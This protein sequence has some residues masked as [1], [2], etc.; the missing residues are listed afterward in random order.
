LRPSS[1]SSWSR[2][3]DW[4]GARLPHFEKIALAIAALVL[5]VYGGVRLQARAAQAQESRAFD[6]A[7]QTQAQERFYEEADQAWRLPGESEEAAPPRDGE[8]SPPESVLRAEALLAP[9]PA[10]DDRDV[11]EWSPRRRRA[12]E[13]TL[14]AG[15]SLPLGRLEIPSIDLSVMV[16]PGTDD[17]TLN[18]AVGHIEGTALPGA[19]EGNV[20]IAGHRDG[21]FR[22]LRHLRQGER[23]HL[24]TLE[25]SYTYEVSDI[26]VV[27]PTRVDVLEPS[28]TPSLTLVTCYPFYHVGSAPQRYI[29]RALLTSPAG[30]AS[31]ART[32]SSR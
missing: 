21:F 13:E 23:I 18:R 10:L 7:L 9:E 29:I 17:W 11:A 30:R 26:Q 1:R 25:G 19:G 32:I 4:S 22:G 3:L 15:Q 8:D 27:H 14:A 31:P 28:D 20:G 12:Y 24:T 16:L 5:A 2:A 6:E